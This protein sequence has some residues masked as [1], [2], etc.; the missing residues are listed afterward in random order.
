M[1]LIPSTRFISEGGRFYLA[2]ALYNKHGFDIRCPTCPGNVGRTGFTRDEAGTIK[3]QPGR[4][5]RQWTCQKS[6]STKDSS[7]CSRASCT[8]Y[9]KLA[10]T[11]LAQVQ[12]QTVL[13]AVCHTY[14]P[15]QD[16]YGNLRAY[17]PRPPMPKRKATE[18]LETPRPKIQRP[19]GL[20]SMME[21]ILREAYGPLTALVEM[22]Q[23]WPQQLAM[24]KM[25]LDGTPSPLP[26]PSTVIPSSSAPSFL[27]DSPK[28]LG[29][30]M[31]SDETEREWSGWFPKIPTR[32]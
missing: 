20:P 1:T 30:S 7:Q 24:L 13:A 3:N 17:L 6:K 27:V 31:V 23:T 15:D 2:E 19:E 11:Q 22:S 4:K 16:E 14:P 18:E 5:R 26:T 12:F 28:I 21:P 10:I 29:S 32:A 8:T 9:I 25:F